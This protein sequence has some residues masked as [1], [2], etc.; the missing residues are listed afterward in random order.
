M[1]SSSS[2]LVYT[3]HSLALHEDTLFWSEYERGEIMS[4]NLR[5]KTVQRVRAANPQL[6]SVKVFDPSKQPPMSHVC[7][8]SPC[9]DLCLVQPGGGYRLDLFPV[10][11]QTG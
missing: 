11:R 6:F 5:N 9:Q 4:L 10:N 7:D 1:S 8:K 2:Y 3:F